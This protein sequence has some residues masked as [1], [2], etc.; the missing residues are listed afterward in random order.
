MCWEIKRCKFDKN[1]EKYHKIAKKD[2]F[3]Y[4]IGYEEDNGFSPYFRDEFI[5]KPNIFNDEIKL[6]MKIWCFE[7][8]GINEGYH[9]YSGECFIEQYCKYDDF[10]GIY[11]HRNGKVITYD[12]TKYDIEEKN[13]KIKMASIGKFIIPKGSE[14]YKNGDGEI[15]SS[16]LIYSGEN[17]NIL[18]WDN[19]TNCISYDRENTN[20]PFLLNDK[21]KVKQLKNICVGQ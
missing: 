10:V 11:S 3:V 2:I 20:K 6:H 7:T 9:S 5:Y 12:C 14:Y 19:L 8:F 17:I 4:K 1:P 21:E 15:V 16:K 18:G 13:I